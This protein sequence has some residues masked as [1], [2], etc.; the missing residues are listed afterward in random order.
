MEITEVK[1]RKCFNRGSVRATVSIVLDKELAVHDIQVIDN[2]QRIFVSMPQRLEKSL[3]RDIVHPINPDFREKLEN[4]VLEKFYGYLDQPDLERVSVDVA[5]ADKTTPY[6]V[7]PLGQE[8][9]PI[10]LLTD[11]EV[12]VMLIIWESPSIPTSTSEIYNAI[13]LS[14][15][16]SLQTLQVVLR[17]LCEKGM[18]VCEKGRQMNYYR[19][20][21]RKEDYLQ[22]TTDNFLTCHFHGSWKLYLSMLVKNKKLTQKD[23]D[24]IRAMLDTKRSGAPYQASEE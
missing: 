13:N 3:W 15:R 20:L 6:S 17:R 19:A 21:V 18:L 23:L 14:E 16:N 9:A 22:F 7:D 2:G 11:R 8:N 4:I 5:K 12:D 10:S 1:I 24:D